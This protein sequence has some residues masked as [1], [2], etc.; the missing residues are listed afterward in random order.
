[1]EIIH[2]E[3]SEKKTLK[4]KILSLIEFR[5]QNFDKHNKF[6]KNFSQIALQGSFADSSQELF[7][8]LQTFFLNYVQEILVIFQNNLYKNEEKKD[9]L[10]LVLLLDGFL[11]NSIR[12]WEISKSQLS[13]KEKSQKILQLFEEVL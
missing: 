10:Y 12:Y 11:Q 1:L 5:I 7:Q 4:D 2:K 13:L 3:L 6:Y 9:P 8:I